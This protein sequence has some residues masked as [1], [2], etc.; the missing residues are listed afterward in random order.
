[1][2]NSIP[3][4]IGNI[5]AGLE[6]HTLFFIYLYYCCRTYVVT[7]AATRWVWPMLGLC[8]TPKE[9]ARSSKTMACKVLSR[10]HTSLVRGHLRSPQTKLQ[11]TQRSGF[12]TCL[13]RGGGR[14]ISD[15]GKRKYI[16]ACFNFSFLFFS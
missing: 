6:T 8:V 16:V 1:M 13:T 14:S 5:V 4:K 11:F 15:G 3:F 7:I 12:G 10:L 2:T 9:A